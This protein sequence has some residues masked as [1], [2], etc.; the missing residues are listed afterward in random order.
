MDKIHRDGFRVIYIGRHWQEIISPKD[1]EKTYKDSLVFWAATAK[2]WNKKM[3]VIKL[4]T[5]LDCHSYN[6]SMSRE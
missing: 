4:P 2:E 3:R 5:Y 1:S 6:R